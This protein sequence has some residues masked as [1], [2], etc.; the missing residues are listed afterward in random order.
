MGLQLTS[1]GSATNPGEGH[2]MIELTAYSQ[3]VQGTWA[4]QGSA[5]YYRYNSWTS[6]A[7]SAQNDAIEY[8]IYLA[9]G[10]YDIFSYVATTS[11]SGIAT[12][13]IDGSTVGTIDQYSGVAV[14]STPKTI[15]SIVIATSGLKTL[16]IISATK[17]AGSSSYRLFFHTLALV[18]TA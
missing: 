10:T 14:N 3:V 9:A 1:G 18:R 12:F 17:N 8:K 13:Q 6:D 15:S 2:I 4:L 5:N 11:S 7:T 16:K